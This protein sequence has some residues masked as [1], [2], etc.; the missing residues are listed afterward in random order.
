MGGSVGSSDVDEF[1]FA[2][3]QHL[4]LGILEGICDILE[5]KQL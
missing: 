5:H 1:S 4:L 3:H 2:A